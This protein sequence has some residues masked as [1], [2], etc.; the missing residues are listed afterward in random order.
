MVPAERWESAAISNSD[1]DLVA[2]LTV[3]AA[4]GRVGCGL[5]TMRDRGNRRG[6]ECQHRSVH[7]DHA[8]FFPDPLKTGPEVTRACLRCHPNAAKDM[9]KTSHWTW[10][11]QKVK[12]P[13][14]DE[15]DA[16]RQAELDQQLLHSRR[17]E[18]QDLLVLPRRLRLG[19]QHV[20]F[21]PEDHVDCLVCHD[22]TG[23]YQKGDAGNPKP[24]VDLMT[25]ARSVGRPTR[26]NCG[27][28]HFKGGGGDAVKHG[29][30]DGSMYFP[31]ERIDV[32][33]GQHNLQCVDCHRTVKHQIPGCAMSVCIERP[34]RVNCTDCHSERPHDHER[35][36]AHTQTVA[37][38]TCHIPRMAI[39][40]P[41]K[42]SWDW[43]AAGQDGRPDDPHV[44]LKSQGQLP[45]RPEP[46][47]RILLV[48]RPR[49]SVLDRRQDRSGASGA[50]Q[51][52]A[53][54]A[55][56]SRT[57]RSGR[58]RCIAASRSTTSS[59]CTC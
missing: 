25:V 8:A 35:L 14:R 54:R 23:S 36:D 13:G 28:C 5:A 7:V 3:V 19:R 55:R 48:Q 53:G 34:M 29:D 18:H 21:H 49:L 37:C 42:M 44:Y 58:S 30:M 51:S 1:V 33:M 41:T 59:C 31:S 6:I 50:D 46:P 11:G 56:R 10:A 57:P 9:M 27:Q 22:Q 32:H 12:L 47:A 2:L 45:V 17:A 15:V 26:S 40:A 38:Q 24:D 52:A 20:R 16:G 4:R 43:S 39:D